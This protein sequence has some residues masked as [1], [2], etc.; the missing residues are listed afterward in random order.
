[1]AN[2]KEVGKSHTTIIIAHRLS[3]IQD[4]DKI[5]VLKEGRVEE[6]GTHAELLRSGGMYQ[7]MWEK[8]QDMQVEE[9]ENEIEEEDDDGKLN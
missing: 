9:E 6:Q 5:V 7:D 3:T 1:M 8:Q 2:L 4:A